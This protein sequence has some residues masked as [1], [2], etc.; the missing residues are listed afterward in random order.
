MKR[1]VL[2]L[3][4]LLAGSLALGGC[5]VKT[6][7]KSVSAARVTGGTGFTGGPVKVKKGD[8]VEIKVS[9]LTDRTHGFAIDAFGVKQT[10]DPGKKIQVKFTPTATGS[11]LIYCQ[12]HPAH[13]TTELI[14][15]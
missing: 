1:A 11:Y 8:K 7:H 10:V 14:V 15:R 13:K 2:V 3:V 12:L 6:T 9:N 4:P 5:G